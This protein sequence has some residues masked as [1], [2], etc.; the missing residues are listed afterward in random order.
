MA[1]ITPNQPIPSPENEPILSFNDEVKAHVS[2]GWKVISDGPSGVQLE[3]PKKM[4][5]LDK[6]CL[7]VGV[8]TFWIYGIGLFFIAVAMLDYWFMTK[9][10]AKF[11]AR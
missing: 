7:A 8:L 5:G 4:R 11:L 9:P 10:E 2:K 3:G 6:L 1:R